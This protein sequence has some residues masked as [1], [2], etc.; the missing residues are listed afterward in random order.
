MR[1][2]HMTTVKADLLPILLP[3][4]KPIIH[5]I[6][7]NN[8]AGTGRTYHHYFVGKNRNAVFYQ[9]LGCPPCK[10]NI[11]TSTTEDRPN[12][13]VRVHLFQLDTEGEF[14][15]VGRRQLVIAPQFEI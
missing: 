14:Y 12:E 11:V 1:T 3:A 6:V 8:R 5:V 4:Y 2:D 15:Y 9:D 13:V 10:T 7:S